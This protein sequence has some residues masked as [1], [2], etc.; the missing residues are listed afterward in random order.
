MYE[1]ELRWWSYRIKA[2]IV[3]DTIIIIIII[4]F[5]QII[6]YKIYPVKINRINQLNTR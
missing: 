1:V 6:V 3:I 5:T 2:S 4:Y